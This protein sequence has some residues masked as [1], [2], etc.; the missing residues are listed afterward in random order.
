M[1]LTFLFEPMAI[2]IPNIRCLFSDISEFLIP[3]LFAFK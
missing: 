1:A 2:N 3:I